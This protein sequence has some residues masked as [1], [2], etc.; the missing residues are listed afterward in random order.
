M[1]RVQNIDEDTAGWYVSIIPA[2]ALFFSPIFG[3]IVDKFARRIYFGIL[4]L[5]L[6][7]LLLPV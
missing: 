4:F 6:V 2:T 3:I 7:L 5:L 1:E